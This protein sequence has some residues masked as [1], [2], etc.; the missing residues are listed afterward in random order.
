MIALITYDTPHK[1]TQD[2]IFSLIAKGY[3]DIHLVVL[4]WVERK[5]F[6]PI[7]KHRPSI[8]I[9]IPVD[10]L[11]KNFELSLT[12][13]GTNDLELF[14]QQ[15]SFDYI[16]IGGAGLLP[17][18]LALKFQ[19]INAHPGYLPAVKGLDALKWAIL[20]KQPIGVS[21]HIISDKADEGWLIDRQIIPVYFEDSFYHLAS[22][23]YEKEIDMLTDAINLLKKKPPLKKLQ[24]PGKEAHRRMPHALEL[25][26]VEK[27]NR[28]RINSPSIFE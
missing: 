15:N 19:I 8:P 18:D 24:N 20:E 2:V 4:P 17:A 10:Q 13:V 11:A 23:L 6:K 1:K 3:K 22:R 26:M 14:F 27:F 5:S 21:T 25:K 28:L 12:R 16:L 7:I 9:N